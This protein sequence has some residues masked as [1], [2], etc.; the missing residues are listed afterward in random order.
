MEFEVKQLYDKQFGQTGKRADLSRIEKY[1]NPI[2]IPRLY[3]NPANYVPLGSQLNEQVEADE[4]APEATT[5]LLGVTIHLPIEIDGYKLP[6][7]PLVT[8]R[9]S[10]KIIETEIDSNDPSYQGT[11]KELFSVGDWEVTIQ[12]IVFNEDNSEDIPEKEIRKLRK[13]FLERKSLPVKNR[14]LDIYKITRL[15]IYDFEADSMEGQIDAQAYT[16][17]CKSDMLWNLE[18]IKPTS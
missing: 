11:F 13:L 12:G 15:A 2:G 14:L 6:N 3:A 17:K 18:N 5:N 4:P 10:K 1:F 7:E 16:L 9:A 8:V